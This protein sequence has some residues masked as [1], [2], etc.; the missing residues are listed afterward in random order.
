MLFPKKSKSLEIRCSISELKDSIKQVYKN[1]KSIR[2][3]SLSDLDKG[4]F[5]LRKRNSLFNV[6]SMVAIAEV[7]GEIIDNTLAYQYSVNDFIKAV[8]LIDTIISILIILVFDGILFAFG[9][10]LLVILLFS[11]LIL[12]LKFKQEVSILEK[13]IDETLHYLVL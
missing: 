7:K 4:V 8:F 3:G 10:G 1:G 9:I 11:W 6:F 12:F 2:L 5:Y 13:E